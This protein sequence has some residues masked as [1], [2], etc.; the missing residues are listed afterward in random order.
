MKISPAFCD[1]L[2]LPR[3]IGVIIKREGVIARV[4][5]SGSGEKSAAQQCDA[6]MLQ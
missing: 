3:F 6:P 5:N 2:Y 1:L 4:G